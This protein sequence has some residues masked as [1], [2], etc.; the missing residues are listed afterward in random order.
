MKI[1]QQN[2]ERILIVDDTPANIDVLGSILMSEYDISVA[3]TGP[4]ALE[5]IESN[6]PPDLVLLDIMMP[7]M[8]GY[9][10]ARRINANEKT[11]Q[12]P[13]IFVTA[14]IQEEDEAFGFK[15]GGV[16][17]IRKPVNASVTLARIKSQLELKRYRDKLTTMVA[18]KTSQFQISEQLLKNKGHKLSKVVDDLKDSEAFAH[19]NQVYFRE[20]FMNSPHGIIMVG[21]DNTIISANK[22]FSTL[23]GYPIDEIVNK[24]SSGFSVPEDLRQAH[25]SLIK[26]A[27]AEN[28]VSMETRCFHKQGFGIHVSALAYAVKLD[29]LVQGVFVFYENIS[30]RKLFEEKL[31]HQAYH[32]ALTGIPNRLL[33][34]ERLDFAIEEQRKNT[35]F[36]F[37]VLLIDLDRFK[38][39][40]D[41]LGHQAGDELL[42][43]VST[44]V[45]ECLRADD[46]LARLGGDEFAVLL[47][48]IK[49]RSEVTAIASRIRKAV[50]ATYI[51][52]EQEVH[53][54]ASIGIV[55]DTKSYETA[56]LLL[57]DADLAMYHAKDSGK[58]QFKFFSNEMHET[59]MASLSIEQDLR[60]AMEREELTLFFQPIVTVST[61]QVEGFE[62]L[63]RW[64]HPDRGMIGPDTF[65]PIA[66]ETGLMVPLGEWIMDRAIRQLAQWQKTRNKGQFISINVS[67]KQFLQ[68]NFIEN[69]CRIAQ[70][71]RVFPSDIKLEFTETLLME[72]TSSAVK[73]L[74]ELKELGFIRVIDDF[75][76]GYSSLSYLQ[77]FS[78]DQIKID[79]SFVDSMNSRQDSY[80]IV[81]SILS[82]SKS[83]GLTTVAE[84]VETLEQL[85]TLSKL[86]C[87]SAQGYFFSKPLPPEKVFQT[88]CT[89]GE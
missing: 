48:D 16:D 79:R 71:Y 75:G 55:I 12:I 61:R 42:K 29:N 44:K 68:Q 46:T 72:H 13:I 40:N 57:R 22:S 53:I 9:E 87:E 74:A 56:N 32:D 69:L 59:L 10:V 45:Q 76:T 70:K 85:S 81:K 3:V 50:E 62:A 4:M 63:V 77:Q 14:K 5:I 35:R 65:I 23:V 78:I 58:A 80:E 86:S 89:T 82:L 66:E 33:F 2:K 1:T 19:K 7:D 18:K 28:T 26:K 39:I 67:I 73:K 37:A 20:L 52:D 54:S 49:S 8:D 38:S 88:A 11:R 34:S 83:L 6:D 64:E 60:K 41:S 31:K 30:Q 24:K 51:I 84:G 21:P 17:Y 15:I 47:Y 36:Q 43:S 25:D 27:L